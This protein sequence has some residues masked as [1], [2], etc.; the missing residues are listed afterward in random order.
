MSR[1]QARKG[2]GKGKGGACGEK[3]ENRQGRDSGLSRK[4]L[5]WVIVKLLEAGREGVRNW[6]GRV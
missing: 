3:T 4:A 2:N 1:D 5:R 6:Q